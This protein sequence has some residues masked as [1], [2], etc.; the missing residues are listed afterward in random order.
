MLPGAYANIPGGVGVGSGEPL[1]RRTATPGGVDVG[2]GEP[3]DLRAVNPGGVG[4][5]RG[6]PL[7]AAT[8]APGVQLLDNRLTE[9]LTGSTIEKARTRNAR[10][11]EMFF[12][13]VENLL[14][15]TMKNNWKH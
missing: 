15:A 1:A 4:V 8:E 9:L 6:D 14:I 11:I 10:R 13:M 12:I 7:R 5:G 3:L 2:S